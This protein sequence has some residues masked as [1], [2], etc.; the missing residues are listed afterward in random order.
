MN[1]DFLE[2]VKK[3][4]KEK[5]MPDTDIEKQLPKLNKNFLNYIR[6]IRTINK[7][8]SNKLLITTIAS[9][10]MTHTESFDEAYNIIKQSKDIIINLEKDFNQKNDKTKQ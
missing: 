4:L 7:E 9:N 8:W 6:G 10:V 5:D 2:F 3:D 1:K